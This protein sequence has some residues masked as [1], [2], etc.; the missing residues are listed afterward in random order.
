[1][2]SL[3]DLVSYTDTLL[4]ASA[5]RDY[6]PN[7]LQLE[8]RA[9]VSRLV[10][11]VSA[12]QALVDAA[13]EAGAHALV[14][15]HGYFWKGEEPVITGIKRRR[16]RALLDAGISLLAYHL[17]LDAHPQYGNNAQLALRLGLEVHGHFGPAGGPDIAM[18]GRLASAVG[19]DELAERITIALGRAPLHV[20]GRGDPIRSVGWCTGAAQ[21]YIDQAAALGLDAY[22]SGEVS[23]PTVHVARE[24]GVHFY[25][26]GHHATERY[27]PQALGEHLAEHFGLEF[28]FIDIDNPV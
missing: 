1:M 27:G 16:I 25:A 28:R 6:C 8:G 22:I 12:S 10:A 26:A 4:D 14:V 5:F 20:P 21:G 9:S 23:E 13:V 17:P 2:V 15:H 24:T 18:Y 19:A 7:G 11:G 3:H